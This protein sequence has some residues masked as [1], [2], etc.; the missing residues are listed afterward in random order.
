MKTWR[1]LAAVAF[2]LLML[3]ANAGFAQ[4]PVLS[5][6]PVETRA[7]AVTILGN[8]SWTAVTGAPYSAIEESLYSQK[9]PDE[10][11]DDRSMI[12]THLYRD[13]QGR[14]RAERYETSYITRDGKPWLRS[15]FITDALAGTSFPST[16]IAPPRA[17]S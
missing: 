10:T 3:F 4:L 8:Q 2:G 7:Q 16:C 13:G 5:I 15:V 12:T 17:R 9:Q 6:D 11:Y 1:N 14:T